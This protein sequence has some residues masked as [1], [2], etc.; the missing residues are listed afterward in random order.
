MTILLDHCVPRRY[1]NLLR[2]WGYPT[3]IISAHIPQDSPDNLVIAT[4]QALGAVLLTIDLDF[5]N[6]VEHPPANYSGIIV[7]RYHAQDETGLDNTLRQVLQDLYRDPLRGA[8]VIVE[9]TR[10]RIR[11]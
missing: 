3:E 7:I 11:R 5:A 8:L 4:A 6:I 9:A 10:Y 1:V 2:G